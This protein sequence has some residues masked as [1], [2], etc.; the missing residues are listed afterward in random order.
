MSLRTPI[1]P[2]LVVNYKM[3]AHPDEPTFEK[4]PPQQLLTALHSSD[5]HGINENIEYPDGED[6]PEVKTVFNDPSDCSFTKRNVVCDTLTAQT[7]ISFK[8]ILHHTRRV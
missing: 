7:Q 8:F 3:R 5:L 4:E 2:A 1:K 6:V